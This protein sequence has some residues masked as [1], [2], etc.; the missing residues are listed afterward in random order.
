M[1]IWEQCISHHACIFIGTLV[2]CCIF[3]ILQ[4]QIE[5]NVHG[6]NFYL[7]LLMLWGFAVCGKSDFCFKLRRFFYILLWSEYTHTV[8]SL[9]RYV[10][11]IFRLLACMSEL[12]ILDVV[13]SLNQFCVLHH[14][15]S[16]SSFVFHS[17]FNHKDG[18]VWVL[19]RI[20]QIADWPQ[21]SSCMPSGTI[22][23]RQKNQVCLAVLHDRICKAL[24]LIKF[25][26]M[27]KT[28]HYVN[29]WTCSF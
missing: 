20:M 9:Y 24:D 7:D 8:C 3:Q 17:I 26:S 1:L 16:C 15:L 25:W 19:Q 29:I 12:C 18:H 28:H 6:S 27:T 5:I 23:V 22:M 11:F 21:I 10:H 2:S 13:T 4:C 14:G